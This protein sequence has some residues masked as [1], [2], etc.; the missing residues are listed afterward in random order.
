[1][2]ILHTN[3][4]TLKRAQTLTREKKLRTISSHQGINSTDPQL[5]EMT[6]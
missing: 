4:T 3:R 2:A 5:M 6:I 1:M